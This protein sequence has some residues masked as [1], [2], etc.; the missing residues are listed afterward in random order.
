MRCRARARPGAL[1]LLWLAACAPHVDVGFSRDGGVLP[2]VEAGES[3]GGPTDAG[4]ASIDLGNGYRTSARGGR[5]VDR[6]ARF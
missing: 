4:V 5:P 6:K 3:G 1:G 2:R